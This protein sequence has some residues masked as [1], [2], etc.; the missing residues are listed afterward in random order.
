MIIVLSAT[1]DLNVV[2]K[3][4]QKGA[5]DYLLKPVQVNAVKNLWQ[6]VWRKRKER[7]Y[8]VALNDERN[9]R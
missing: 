6:N 2:Y 1:E 4:L 3:C 5:D 9:K 8:D 7:N